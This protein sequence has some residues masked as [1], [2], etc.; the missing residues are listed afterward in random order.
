MS[1]EADAAIVATGGIIFLFIFYLIIL[2][3]QSPYVNV[4]AMLFTLLGGFIGFWLLYR[5]I[6]LRDGVCG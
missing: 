5:K 6:H 4:P 1:A 2:S 3:T